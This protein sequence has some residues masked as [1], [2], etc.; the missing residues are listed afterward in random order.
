MEYEQNV[1]VATVLTACG[2]ETISI[3]FIKYVVPPTVATVLTACG[4]ETT[5]A[6]F[7]VVT[8]LVA[9]VLTACGIETLPITGRVRRNVL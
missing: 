2:I 3:S 1:Q 4:I 7:Y 9:T 5:K 6:I 8:S